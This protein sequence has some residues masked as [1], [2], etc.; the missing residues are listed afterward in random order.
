MATNNSVNTNLSGQTGTGS[1]VG[2]SQPTISQNITTSGTIPQYRMNCTGAGV[3]EKNWIL[4]VNTGTLSIATATDAAPGSGQQNAWIATRSGITVSGQQFLIGNNTKF[5]IGSSNNQFFTPL[6]LPNGNV[7]TG[8]T[9]DISTGSSSGAHSLTVEA[10]EMTSGTFGCNFGRITN[11]ST[12]VGYNF[13]RGDGT[14]TLLADINRSGFRLGGANARVNAILT[15]GTMAAAAD[16][17]IYTGLAIKTYIDSL[18]AEIVQ[19]TISQVSA[20]SDVNTTTTLAN[21][22]LTGGITPTDDANII[23]GF[24]CFQANAT[25]PSGN[26]ITNFYIVAD[27]YRSTGTPGSITGVFQGGLTLIA[28]STS[29]TANSQ[30]NFNLIFQEVAGDTNLH[31]YVVRFANGSASGRATFQPTGIATLFILELKV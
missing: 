23:L 25:N 21:S 8:Y 30:N 27:V 7:G 3:D 17:N 10:T 1:F 5:T 4:R 26:N 12:G 19:Y 13:Y 31:T 15:D 24:A 14:S 16:T 28:P 9:I 18:A 20:P 2:S 29:T 6:V 11:T 22:S